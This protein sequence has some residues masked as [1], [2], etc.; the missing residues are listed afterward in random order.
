MLKALKAKVQQSCVCC[1]SICV[2]RDSVTLQ[3]AVPI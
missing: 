1:A 3:Q 2:S